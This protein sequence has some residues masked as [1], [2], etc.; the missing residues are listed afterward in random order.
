MALTQRRLSVRERE[1]LEIEVAPDER[2]PVFGQ[3]CE[4][5]VQVTPLATGQHGGSIYSA[6]PRAVI[7]RS[8]YAIPCAQKAD[9]AP[10]LR[11]Q[12]FGHR[13]DC[14]RRNRLGIYLGGLNH[15]TISSR[16]ELPSVSAASLGALQRRAGPGGLLGLANQWRV[17]RLAM[18]VQVRCIERVSWMWRVPFSR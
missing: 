9:P 6:G 8:G 1:A 16:V 2:S 7:A 11:V 3:R 5:R 18:L 14:G 10:F 17:E 4:M 15:F 13:L 12:P